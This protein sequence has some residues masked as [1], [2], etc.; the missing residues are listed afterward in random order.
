MKRKFS[1]L[2]SHQWSSQ[3]T[4][5]ILSPLKL[6]LSTVL[7]TNVTIPYHPTL[8]ESQKRNYSYLIIK[9]IKKMWYIYT[10]EYYSAIKK[11]E[12]MPFAAT[13][14]QV[15]SIILSEVSRTEKDKYPM[16]LLICRIWNT[17]ESICK[18]D[19]QT[20][21]TDLWLPRRRKLGLA[22]VSYCTWRG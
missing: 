6:F 17:S 13:Q 11:N 10:M 19:S 7:M 14:I 18:A 15:E 9:W 16:I 3:L 1:S 20:R 21:R 4:A 5:N 22:E 8:D 2:F 12:I